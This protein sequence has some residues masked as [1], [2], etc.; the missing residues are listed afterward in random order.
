MRPPLFSVLDLDWG[1]MFLCAHYFASRT[2][3]KI[4][5]VDD[6]TG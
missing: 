4:A 5:V 2:G 1:M 6:I 3:G